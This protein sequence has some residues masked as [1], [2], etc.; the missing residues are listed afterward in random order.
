MGLEIEFTSNGIELDN[1]SLSSLCKLMF[2]SG[3]A[4]GAAGIYA[5]LQIG[6]AL[7]TESKQKKVFHHTQPPRR[8][9]THP[10]PNAEGGA[11]PLHLCLLRHDLGFGGCR[12]LPL[13]HLWWIPEGEGDLRGVD[14]KRLKDKQRS[15][16]PPPPN[17]TPPLI[18]PLLH[19]PTHILFFG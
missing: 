16:P 4:G 18:P 11:E 2:T 13:P 12:P 1:L 19:L 10:T 15:K 14:N 6:A 7:F 9:H 5:G 17:N 3:L 8:T